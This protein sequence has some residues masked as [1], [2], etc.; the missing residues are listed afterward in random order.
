MIISYLIPAGFF[1]I[2]DIHFLN[3][4]TLS[5]VG[6]KILKSEFLDLDHVKLYP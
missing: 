6:I 3:R 1:S 4:S 5:L 2:E